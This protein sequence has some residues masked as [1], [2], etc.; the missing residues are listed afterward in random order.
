MGRRACSIH[1]KAGRSLVGKMGLGWT[2]LA[3]QIRVQKS[4]AGV[5]MARFHTLL[6]RYKVGRRTLRTWGASVVWDGIANRR[7][8]ALAGTA[9]GRLDWVPHSLLVAV[10]SLLNRKPQ[11]KA[12]WKDRKI[13]RR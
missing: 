13:L 6:S 5:P 4:S 8:G 11:I 7:L 9:H 2:S 10:L 3:L 12:C 1:S